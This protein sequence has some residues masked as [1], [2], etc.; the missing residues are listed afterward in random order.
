VTDSYLLIDISP[1]FIRGGNYQSRL[2]KRGKTGQGSVIQPA[3]EE[4]SHWCALGA[5]WSKKVLARARGGMDRLP[6]G[7]DA[8][9]GS[10]ARRR[11]L[12]NPE[13]S[14]QAPFPSLNWDQNR[15]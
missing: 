14:T 5:L 11:V 13:P 3:E 4:G 15:E 6:D 9:S 12:E 2:T 8:D 10:R 1:L 7:G